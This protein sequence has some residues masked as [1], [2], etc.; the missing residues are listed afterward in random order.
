MT[1]ILSDFSRC[2]N[3]GWLALKEGMLQH[4]RRRRTAG[5]GILRHED[6]QITKSVQVRLREPQLPRL[7][8]VY[9]VLQHIHDTDVSRLW[10]CDIV[11]YANPPRRDLNPVYF[12]LYLLFT[13][14][15]GV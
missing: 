5:W 3:Q 9:G 11:S 15:R 10:C 2:G 8:P 6:D 1:L 13:L 14:S 7:K 12:G 4:L